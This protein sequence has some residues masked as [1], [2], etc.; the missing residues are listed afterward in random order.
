VDLETRRIE[1]EG[2]TFTDEAPPAGRGPDGSWLP[3][4]AHVRIRQPATLVDATV[5]PVTPEEPARGGRWVVETDS[6]VWAIAPGQ[7]CVLYDGRRCL[8]GG[9]IAAPARQPFPAA[10]RVPDPVPA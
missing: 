3:F 9:R 10:E 4:L 8:G 6:P 7:A 1:L 5:R 2:G